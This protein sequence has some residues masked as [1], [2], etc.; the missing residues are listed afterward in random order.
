VS[1]PLGLSLELRIE[2]EVAEGRAS[3]VAAMLP[4]TAAGEPPEWVVLTA[5]YH[6]LGMHEVAEGEDG[7]WN[8]ADDN[9]S[10]T[11]TVLEIARRLGRLERRDRGVLVLFVSGEERG[12]LGSAF[13]AERPLVPI[14]RVAI[15]VNVD[16]VGRSTGSVQALT[17]GFEPLFER[18]AEI[19]ETLDIEVLPDQQLSWRLLYLTDHYHFARFGVPA[20][21]FFTGLHTDYHQPSDEADAIRYDEL[22]RILEVMYRLTEEYVQGAEKPPFERP[23]WFIT[24]DA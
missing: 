22:G 8:G 14:D 4:P 3:N 11:A 19:G 10:G 12:L 1:R 20:V 7:I 18:I 6:H 24:S 13:H 23:E 9:A 5:H 17:H 15:D 2:A 21:E 16:M